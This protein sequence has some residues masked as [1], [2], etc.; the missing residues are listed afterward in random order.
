MPSRWFLIVPLLLGAAAPALAQLPSTIAPG[1]Y[2]F[3]GGHTSPGSAVSAGLALADRFLG[4]EPFANP[5]AA[6]ASTLSLSPALLRVSRQDLRAD[7]RNY[8]EQPAFFDAA[9]GWFGW[10]R[11]PVGLTLYGYQPLLRLEDN[12]F[13]RGTQLGPPLIV[14]SNTS[15]RE[16]RLGIGLSL[17]R[18]RARVGVAPEW[19]HRSDHYER[20][21]TGGPAPESRVADFS[22]G[23]VGGQAG[24]RLAFGPEG[25]GGFTLGGAARWVP[26][27]TLEGDERLDLVAGKSANRISTRREAGWEGG[28]G[29]SYAATA[30]FRIITS[31]GG[32]SGQNFDRFGVRRGEGGEWKLA[33]EFHDQR[34]P[35]TAR[36]G[37]GAEHESG[38]AEPRAGV[39]GIGFGW[40]ME[41]TTLELG[42]FRRSFE[43]SGHPSS[44]D[45]RML[46]GIVQKF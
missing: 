34:D 1:L 21:E 22:G 11:G 2:A 26:E 46:I 33:G 19:T 27:L 23:G 44:A 15:A 10:A 36:F 39:V 28:I 20:L 25:A 16:L 45:E 9:G 3:P 35:W 12:A 37:F 7:N 4:D 17:A 43:R 30:A 38:V 13:N 8:D 29:L 40:I 5:A 18:G 14:Q 31:A 41:S 24:L 42:A 6:R 32:R